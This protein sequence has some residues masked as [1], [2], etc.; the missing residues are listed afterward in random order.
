[1]AAGSS[2]Q[3]D[4]FG[5]SLIGDLL[6]TPTPVPTQDSNRNSK[7]EEVDLFADA[8]FVSTPTS[9]AAPG[10]QVN[11]SLYFVVP[12]LNSPAVDFFDKSSSESVRE[13]CQE[14]RSDRC[15]DCWLSVM[16]NFRGIRGYL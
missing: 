5:D 7:S 1:A 3:V 16:N 10:S 2:P 6:D 14:G 13:P 15:G 8:A 4:L 12:V 9:V 11:S